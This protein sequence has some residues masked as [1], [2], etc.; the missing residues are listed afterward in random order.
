MKWKLFQWILQFDNGFVNDLKSQD[1]DFILALS[2]IK[3][4]LIKK[5]ISVDEADGLLLT[6]KFVR[7]SRKQKRQ[8]KFT[9]PNNF[10]MKWIRIAH[11]YVKMYNWIFNVMRICGLYSFAVSNFVLHSFAAFISHGMILF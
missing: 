9:Y 8:P 11:F 5:I 3:Y 7:D 1:G 10:N 4:L 6:E 2:T